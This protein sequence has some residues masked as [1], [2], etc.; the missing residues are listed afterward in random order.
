MEEGVQPETA[1]YTIAQIITTIGQRL[2]AS[3]GERSQSKIAVSL[4][5]RSQ[6]KD[7]E[8][9]FSQATMARHSSHFMCLW[10]RSFLPMWQQ[11]CLMQRHLTWTEVLELE[12]CPFMCWS[13]AFLYLLQ[14][15]LLRIRRTEIRLDTTLAKLRVRLSGEKPRQL[16]REETR[17]TTTDPNH[18]HASSF[19]LHFFKNKE[20]RKSWT[21]GGGTCR[22]PSQYL[23]VI[24]SAIILALM[25]FTWVMFFSHYDACCTG[26]THAVV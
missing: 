6:A 19:C 4:S 9:Q 7:M 24:S 11:M 8:M 3:L 22:Y 21:V 18:C 26:Q 2:K 10:A 16:G 15:F 25:T 12:P 20:Q 23:P 1:V 17:R 5:S 14:V 13:D